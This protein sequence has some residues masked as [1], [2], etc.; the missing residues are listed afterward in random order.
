MIAFTT[1]RQNTTQ[2]LNLFYLVKIFKIAIRFIFVLF[3]MIIIIAIFKYSR[4]YMNLFCRKVT[5][6]TVRNMNYVPM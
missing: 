5:Q 6:L 1:F 4:V 3:Q 2:S